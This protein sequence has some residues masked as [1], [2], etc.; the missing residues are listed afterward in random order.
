[1]GEMDDGRRKRW[2]EFDECEKTENG[3][4]IEFGCYFG[5]N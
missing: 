5:S 4:T 2:K 3:E 1:M